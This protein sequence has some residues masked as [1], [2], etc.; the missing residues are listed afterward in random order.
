MPNRRSANIIYFRK[1]NGT[2]RKQLFQARRQ[3]G[4]QRFVLRLIEELRFACK[5]LGHILAAAG[6]IVD[7][8]RIIVVLY[9]KTSISFAESF[10]VDERK[11]T[12]SV[13]RH[14]SLA[15]RLV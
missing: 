5:F 2:V 4:Q 7:L 11:I 14:L 1:K 8:A 12:A 15:L 13:S 10:I 6:L 3:R 9:H